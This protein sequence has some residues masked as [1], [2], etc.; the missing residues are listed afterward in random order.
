MVAQSK[1]LCSL[2]L[3]VKCPHRH[4]RVGVD[5]NRSIVHF[6]ERLN[7]K[8]IAPYCILTLPL[9]IRLYLVLSTDD[10]AAKVGFFI[11]YIIHAFASN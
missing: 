3:L 6:R 8:V 4:I 9:Y 2:I 7:L 10:K 1:R 5:F 11:H